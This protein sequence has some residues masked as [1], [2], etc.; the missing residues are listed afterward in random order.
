M[1]MYRLMPINCFMA[2]MEIYWLIHQEHCN[3]LA[4]QWALQCL[5]P[6][7]RPMTVTETEIGLELKMFK[8]RVN[9]D[10]AAYKKITTDQ[11]VQAQISD[12]SGFVDTRINSGKSENQ[13]V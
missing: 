9:L 4:D 6:I 12:A 5:I 10:V 8:N 1:Q 13:G 3:L 7:L 2:S 11:I